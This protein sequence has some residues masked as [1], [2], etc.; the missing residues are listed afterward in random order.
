MNDNLLPIG[1]FDSGVGGLTVV[2]EILKNLPDEKIIYFGD[3]A[4][5]PYGNK[6]K[7]TIIRYAEQITAFLLSKKVKAV[8]VACN[9]ASALA[10]ETVR[11]NIDVPMIGVVEPGAYAATAATS[12]HSIGIIGTNATC[13]S[14]VY[15]KYIRS[16]D[17]SAKVFSQPCPLFVH[18]VEEGMID[19]PVTVQMI[20]RYIDSMV[21]EDNIDA[22]ILG[23]THYP[24]LLPVISRE[25][26][27]KER[28][29]TLVDPA[30][31]TALALKALLEK[32]GLAAD[33]GRRVLPSDHCY[34]VSDGPENFRHFAEQVLDI[35]IPDVTVKMLI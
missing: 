3:T 23:C 31:E 35:R 28:G 17:P 4:R 1:V 29:I 33:P 34:F 11:A 25:I 8:T 13:S 5:V 6:S 20:H 21:R 2:R 14:G 7:D 19:D 12:N 26:K 27:A 24:L 22:L 18:L 32:E 30:H 16:L 10:L 9:T 15:E